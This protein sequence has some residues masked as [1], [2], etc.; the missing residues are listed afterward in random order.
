METTKITFCNLFTTSVI[1]LLSYLSKNTSDDFK[2]ISCITSLIQFHIFSGP[3]VSVPSSHS[4]SVISP[5]LSPYHRNPTCRVIHV[6]I[7][8]VVGRGGGGNARTTRTHAWDLDRGVD[9][10]DL[11]CMH[12]LHIVLKPQCQQLCMEVTPITVHTDNWGGSIAE[13][14]AEMW[15]LSCL[16]CSHRTQCSKLNNNNVSN[17]YYRMNHC[18]QGLTWR[19]GW[20]ASLPSSVSAQYFFFHSLFSP[21]LFLYR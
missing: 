21:W 1:T 20:Y 16:F 4:S 2:G 12:I 10:G 15:G 17:Y 3:N 6:P 8:R 13:C 9:E 19:L 18:Q 11:L 7:S 14:L 5:R